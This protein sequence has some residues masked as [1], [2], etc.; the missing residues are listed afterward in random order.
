MEPDIDAMEQ[1]IDAME[2]DVDATAAPVDAVPRPD[3][4]AIPDDDSGGCCSTGRDGPT[5]IASAMIVMGLLGWRRRRHQP[6]RAHRPRP[7]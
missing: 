5:A 2:P 3:A 4:T 1:D 6:R 7:R